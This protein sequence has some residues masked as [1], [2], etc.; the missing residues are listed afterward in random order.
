M[1]GGQTLNLAASRPKDFGY[2][3]VFSSGVLFGMSD[4]WEKQHKAGLEDPAARKGL[5]LL[6]FATGKEDFL[7]PR[8]RETVALWKKY[9]FAPVFQETSGGHTWINWRVYLKEFAPQLFR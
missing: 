4:D 5:K 7:M 9:E 8:T 1:G 3:G 6:W 2:V